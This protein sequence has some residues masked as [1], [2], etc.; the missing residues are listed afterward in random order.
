MSDSEA[1]YNTVFS[2]IFSIDNIP[3][4]I[5]LISSDINQLLAITVKL[6][7]IIF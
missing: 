4:S 2:D 1:E 7:Q 3:D 6:H 5:T